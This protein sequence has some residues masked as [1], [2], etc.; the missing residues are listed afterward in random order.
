[1]VRHVALSNIRAE[2]ASSGTG[3]FPASDDQVCCSV[4]KHR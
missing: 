2:I 4:M 3:E 1:M